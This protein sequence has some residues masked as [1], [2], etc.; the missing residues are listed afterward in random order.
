MNG[1]AIARK[2]N[3]KGIL[4]ALVA[5]EDGTFGVYKRCENY[6]AHCKGGISRTWRYVEKDMTQEA[7]KALY[8]RRTA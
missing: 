3:A 2:A 6:A 8:D 5:Y 1:K 7:A 4:F